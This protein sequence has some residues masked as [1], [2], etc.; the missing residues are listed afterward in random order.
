MSDPRFSLLN[1]WLTQH[2]AS[3]PISVAGDA[4]F[5]RYFRVTQSTDEGSRSLIAMDAPP[6]KEDSSPFVERAR[7][8]LAEGIRAPELVAVDLEQGFMLLEDFGDRQLLS[9]L[10]T[11][12]VEAYYGRAMDDLLKLQ[13]HMDTRELGDYDSDL[14]QREM[15]LFDEWLLEKHLEVRLEDNERRILNISYRMLEA[16]ALEQ[17]QVFVH[18]DY[19]SRNLMVLSEQPPE[20]G[21]IDFQD[22]VAGPITYDLVS[23][24]RDCYIEWPRQ[25]VEEWVADYHLRAVEAGLTHTDGETFLR[26]FDWMGVQRHLK[27]AGIFA[28]L[29]HRDGKVGYLGDIPRTLGY[30]LDV[31][32]RYDTLK[33]FAALL[34]KRQIAERV[35]A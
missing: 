32:Q 35:A 18:R 14:L 5:R 9:K 7:A 27:A 4:S 26:W 34:L 21:M 15:S 11:T 8:L 3:H 12:T 16:N 19:H 6:D 1:E 28:R 23:L 25:R 2:Q 20:L 30:I 13:T 24:L 33:P 22:A 29:K 31:C 17:P 10:D